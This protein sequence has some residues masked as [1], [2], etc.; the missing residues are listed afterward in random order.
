MLRL[1]KYQT[2]LQ[3]FFTRENENVKHDLVEFKVQ[4]LKIFC[5]HGNKSTILVSTQFLEQLL[6]F[7]VNFTLLKYVKSKKSYGFLI[8]KELIFGFQIL[9]LKDHFSASLMK[10]VLTRYKS[11]M[12]KAQAAFTIGH[13]SN[14]LGCAVQIKRCSTSMD[15]QYKSGTSIFS[16]NKNMKYEVGTSSVQM[17]MCNTSEVFH[18]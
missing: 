7:L 8:T 1:R 17:S 10:K 12:L 6:K 2:S 13:F 15:V 16:T 11:F 5:Y 9:D 18:Q 3:H 4:C 14:Q